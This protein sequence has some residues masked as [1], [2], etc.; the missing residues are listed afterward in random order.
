LPILKKIAELNQGSKFWQKIDC[1]SEAKAK[2]KRIFFRKK[3]RSERQIIFCEA[4]SLRF[5]S[6]SHFC[7]KCENLKE[8]FAHKNYAKFFAYFNLRISDKSSASNLI[9]EKTRY[10]VGV[11]Q[12]LT[13]PTRPVLRVKIDRFLVG[14]SVIRF[15]SVGYQFCPRNLLKFALQNLFKPS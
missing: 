10:S 9:Y 13:S 3:L 11:G 14:R 2:L 1:E 12:V 8:N 7:E 4:N 6:F 5:R 15:L